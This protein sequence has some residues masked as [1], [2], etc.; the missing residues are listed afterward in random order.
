MAN[1]ELLKQG[2]A[3]MYTVPP[4]VRYVERFQAAQDDAEAGERGVWGKPSNSALLVVSVTPDAPG[5]DRL[6]LDGEYATFK[7]LVSGTLLGYSI[8]D[9][10]G[11][12]YDFPDRIF[13]KGDVFKLH[14]GQGADRQ[15]DLYWGG[16]EPIW[17]N[18]HD[19]VKVLDPADQIVASY[20]Y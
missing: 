16:G 6:N 14:S 3:T 11:H 1:E 10:T 20:D 7:V 19:T 5:E 15:T 12:R 13:K 18:D 17:N 8:E 2:L 4:N 9:Q